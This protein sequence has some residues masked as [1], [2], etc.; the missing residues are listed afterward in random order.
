MTTTRPPRLVAGVTG[1]RLNLLP[2]DRL[3]DLAAALAA[4]FETVDAARRE[5]GSR[6]RP[7]LMTSL[8]EGTD[9]LACA[10]ARAMRWPMDA[11]IPYSFARYCEDFTS[12]G[13]VREFFELVAA[14]DRVDVLDGA[15]IDGVRGQYMGYAA[16]AERLAAASGLLIAVWNGAPPK[17][18][19]GTAEVAALALE[20]GRPVIWIAPD[21]GS[22]K[23]ILPAIAPKPRSFR[24]RLFQALSTRYA[25][26]SRPADMRR[27]A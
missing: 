18:P 24:A 3:S 10:A 27:A 1:H 25:A 2:A 20:G 19:G 6:L 4:A 13:S 15:S 12:P 22:A 9:R 14:C 7:R 5:A 11:V 17:G 23:L 16:A 8:A 21:G 26:I